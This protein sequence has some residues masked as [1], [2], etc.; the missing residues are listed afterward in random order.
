MRGG[1]EPERE[2]LGV[3]RRLVGPPE[4]FDAGLQEFGACVAAVTEHRPEIAIARRFA[5]ERRSEIVARDRNGEVGA[6][7]E[8]AAAGGGGQIHALADVFA[9]EVEER[10]GRLQDG[11]RNA[12]V[13]GALVGGDQRL[14]PRIRPFRFGIHARVHRL[15]S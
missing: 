7:A 13:A 10:L 11:G 15:S 4:G 2:H 9:R 14:R 12:G 5:G 8:F 1:F 3:G 6:Q